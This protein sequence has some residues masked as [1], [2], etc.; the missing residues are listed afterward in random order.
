MSTRDPTRS[1]NVIYRRVVHETRSLT[2][3]L[4]RER[5]KLSE[6]LDM[7]TPCVAL[8]SGE[9]H[10][11]S[12]E[13]LILLSENLPWYLHELARL[14]FVLRK[15][16]NNIFRVLGDE[17]DKRIIYFL[18]YRKLSVEGVEELKER[19]AIQLIKKYRTLVFTTL[20]LDLGDETQGYVYEE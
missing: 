16:K 15:E 10:C 18:L 14:P 3:L 7:Y 4:P 12:K 20:S 6:A 11:F 1:Y 8:R 19:E 17:W 13:E 5:I 9:E 2:G